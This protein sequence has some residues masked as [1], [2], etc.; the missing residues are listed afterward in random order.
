MPLCYDLKISE[1]SPLVTI[2]SYHDNFPDQ[3]CLIS[4][5]RGQILAVTGEGTTCH[6]S[7]NNKIM[8]LCYYP[9][10]SEL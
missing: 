9:K 8:P 4:R 10:I 5:T 1:L 2:F 3:D 6:I 7:E